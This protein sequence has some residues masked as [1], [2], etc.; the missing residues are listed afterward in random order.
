MVLKSVVVISVVVMLAVPLVE[1]EAVMLGLL[2]VFD[3]P[4]ILVDK[5]VDTIFER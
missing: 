5:E 2:V 1:L 4:L 3:V